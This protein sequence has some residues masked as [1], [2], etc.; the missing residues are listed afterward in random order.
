MARKKGTHRTTEQLLKEA[1]ERAAALRDRARKDD[2][3]RRVIIGSMLLG[4][5]ERDAQVRDQ[6]LRDLDSWLTEWHNRRLF[7]DYGLG[8]IQ[9]LYG[10]TLHPAE[11]AQGWAFSRALPSATEPKRDRYGNLISG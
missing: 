6:L 8:A 11:Q 10:A 2:T 9:G 3:R 1:E 5:A 4:R 7:L